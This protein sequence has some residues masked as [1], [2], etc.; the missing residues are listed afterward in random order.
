MIAKTLLRS[1]SFAS[2]LSILCIAG[3][4]GFLATSCAPTDSGESDCDSNERKAVVDGKTGCYTECSSSA[5]CAVD[6]KCHSAGVCVGTGGGSGSGS[7]TGS[8]GKMDTGVG[9]G[10]NDTGGSGGNDTGGSGGGDTSGLPDTGPC[11]NPGQLTCAEISSCSSENDCANASNQA[12]CLQKCIDKGT[13]SA[14]DQYTT[15][16]GCIRNKCSSMSASATCAYDK[17]E[18]EIKDCGLTGTSTC[19]K[20]QICNTKCIQKVR[21]QAGPNTTQDQLLQQYRMCASMCEDGTIQAMKKQAKIGDCLDKNCSSMSAANDC[22]W[23]NCSQEYMTCG[24]M[25]SKSCKEID[26]CM[27]GCSDGDYKCESEC[28]WKGSKE[29][30]SNR[31]KWNGCIQDNCG[32]ATNP[33]DCIFKNC[34]QHR[35]ACGEIGTKHSSCQAIYSCFQGCGRNDAQCQAKCLYDGTASAQKTYF[36]FSSCLRQNMCQSQS[37]AQ[38]NCSTTY[39]KCI[40]TGM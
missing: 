19:S 15:F 24:V 2:K 23:Q 16:R 28:L 30:R 13:C 33:I 20:L 22:Q 11:T 37:C 31:S 12:Q 34:K 32:S 35:Q 9:T 10:G 7:D 39:N 18:Q 5:D 25:G 26:L 8:G 38:M 29:G 6:E 4:I 1:K 14:Q 27:A 17:C 36:K 21:D 3:A 40:G